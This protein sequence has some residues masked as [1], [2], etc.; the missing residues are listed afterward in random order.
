MTKIQEE[1]AAITGGNSGIG[2]VSSPVVVLA[3]PTVQKPN[4][5]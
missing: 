1:I 4:R 5:T 3:W 2:V